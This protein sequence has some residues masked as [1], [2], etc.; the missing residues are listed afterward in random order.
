MIHPSTVDEMD[1]DGYIREKTHDFLLCEG[2]LMRFQVLCKVA[3]LEVIEDDAAQ[4]SIIQVIVDGLDDPRVAEGA[5][6]GFLHIIFREP[7]HIT[8]LSDGVRKNFD[9][10]LLVV[11]ESRGFEDCAAATFADLFEQLVAPDSVAGFLAES[12][13]E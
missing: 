7:L 3:L 2:I 5:C 4:V 13:C 8:V 12:A 1:G 11:D 9:G 6:E 10:T